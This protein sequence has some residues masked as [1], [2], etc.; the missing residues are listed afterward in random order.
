M[1]PDDRVD[2]EIAVWGALGLLVGFLVALAIGVPP[3]NA[4]VGIA[5][6]AV[7]TVGVRR[8]ERRLRRR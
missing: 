1:T 6:V 2:Q 3:F 7:G 5:V 8:L 4:F